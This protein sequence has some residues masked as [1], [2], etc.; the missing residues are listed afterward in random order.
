[1]MTLKIFRH[2]D[3]EHSHY[4]SEYREEQTYSYHKLRSRDFGG[5]AEWC[6][7]CITH[8]QDAG[9]RLRKVG[10]LSAAAGSNAVVN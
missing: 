9:W 1:M 6:S 3:S 4:L 2:A 5:A 10:E 7:L 8:V